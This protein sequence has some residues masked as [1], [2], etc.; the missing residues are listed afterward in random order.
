MS[1]LRALLA[2]LLV[3][4]GAAGCGGGAGK[5]KTT[6]A[7]AKTTATT[8]SRQAKPAAKPKPKPGV[9]TK[10]AAPKPKGPQHLTKPTLTLDA[11]HI[12]AAAVA[13]NCGTFTIALDVK[14]APKTTASFVYLARKGF[15][16]NLTFQRIVRGFVIQGGDPT[17]SGQG[18]PGYAVVEAPPRSLRYTR[19]V[20]AM[21][22]TEIED[23]GTSGSQFYVVTGPVAQL[24]PDYALVGKVSGGQ[25]V[26]DSI[27]VQPTDTN[28]TARQPDKPL[29]PVVIRSVT[30]AERK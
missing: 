25:D 26:V 29:S 28:P 6:G 18:G 19:G 12:Y 15:Y 16:D 5:A 21:A 20:V 22:K 27:G 1:G 7:K 11:K 10:V 13:T 3:S 24:P 23:P 2:C 30:I 9:C 4:L 17:G 8:A 14:R